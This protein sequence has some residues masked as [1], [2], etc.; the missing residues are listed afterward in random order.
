MIIIDKISSEDKK[1]DL[2]RTR[3]LCLNL[4]ALLV[5]LLFGT[6]GGLSVGYNNS[7][8]SDVMSYQEYTG[9]HDP[10]ASLENLLRS[11]AQLLSSFEE[12]LR[13]TNTTLNETISFLDSFEDLLR[14]QSVLYSGFES[15]LKSQWYR[16]N[17]DEQKKFLESFEDLLHRETILFA[18][19]ANHTQ[20]SWE[21][22]PREQQ[23]K[24]TASF[25][26]LLRRQTNLLK[27]FE[28][29]YKMTNGGLTL[30]KYADKSCI[31]PGDTV[32][33][34]FVVKNWYNQSITKV[35]I[36]DDH[37]GN[38]AQNFTLGPG[39]ERTFS[40]KT[41]LVGAT[42]NTARAYGEGPCGELLIDDSNTVCINLLI[43]TGSN[44]DTVVVGRQ[45]AFSSGS[46]PPVAS[47]AVEIKKNQK[48]NCQKQ[49]NTEHIRLGDQK[50]AG[51][52]TGQSS[53]EIK[54]VT[55]QE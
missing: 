24:L 6:V 32:T 40:K 37:L 55:N 5:I 45:Y 29:L 7:T 17:C 35:R 15:I 16:M 2:T 28:D 49:N 9:S 51:I 22:L 53:N 21:V 10:I 31:R 54:I 20:E 3:I 43:L 14:R 12:Q 27:G 19:F 11:E 8:T 50:A 23:V 34:R 36:V 46:D 41:V 38:I 26:D 47:N 42:C 44:L 25:E 1:P 39:E 13:N 33:Y 4:L 48:I 18:S 52:A 30:E